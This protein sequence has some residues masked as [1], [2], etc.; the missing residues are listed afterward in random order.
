MTKRRHVTR[1]EITYTCDRCN[2]W[3]HVDADYGL[4]IVDS[5]ANLMAIGWKVKHN[6][7]RMRTHLC[8]LCLEREVAPLFAKQETAP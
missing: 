6:A 4:A 2:P 3:G 8:F 5:F 7:D 1:V